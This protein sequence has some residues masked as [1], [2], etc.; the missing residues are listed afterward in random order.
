MLILSQGG[1]THAY[2]VEFHSEE[3]RDYYVNVDKVHSAYKEEVISYLLE[4]GST[5]IV[6]FTPG[7]FNH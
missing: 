2:V 6:D 7:V 1:V 3:D 5:R 4:G